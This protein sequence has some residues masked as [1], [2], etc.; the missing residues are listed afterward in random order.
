MVLVSPVSFAVG[1]W[2]SGEERCAFLTVV[3]VN[4][5]GG[6]LWGYVHAYARAA[7][8]AVRLHLHLTGM[9]FL[10]SFITRSRVL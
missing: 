9:M 8:V 7:M 6:G 5:W 10:F 2:F 1:G 4:L 3:S